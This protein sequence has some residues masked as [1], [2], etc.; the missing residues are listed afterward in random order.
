MD[1]IAPVW[2]FESQCTP[3]KP[4]IHLNAA[5]CAEQ[6]T[7]Q[8]LHATAKLLPVI[9]VCCLALVV[10]ND[11]VVC[12]SGQKLLHTCFE[13]IL[14][15]LSLFH[16]LLS[17]TR[18]TTAAQRLGSPTERP[19][20]SS[21]P[22]DPVLTTKA[23][24]RRPAPPVTCNL[25]P[26]PFFFLLCDRAHPFTGEMRC[27]PRA[28]PSPP[29]LSPQGPLHLSTFRHF[30][31]P[32]PI[33]ILCRPLQHPSCCMAPWLLAKAAQKY[34][35]RSGPL[36]LVSWGVGTRFRAILWGV[37][38]ALPGKMH[39]EVGGKEGGRPPQ[40]QHNKYRGWDLFICT[41]GLAWRRRVNLCL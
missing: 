18:F 16:L 13:Q 28:P 2:P 23:R 36:G 15:P 30:L 35:R 31:P 22:S 37:S 4:I 29:A 14:R 41:S 12:M 3:Y 25:L 32:C 10:K 19:R 39:G 20:R 8:I 9:H 21:R 7:L 17:S 1:I 11:T 34:Q 33:V 5:P 38:R 40:Q 24:P 27:A 26:A 6:S